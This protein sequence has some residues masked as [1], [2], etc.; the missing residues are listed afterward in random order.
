MAW[1]CWLSLPSIN[2]F[3][4]YSRSV[5]IYPNPTNDVLNITNSQIN[6]PIMATITN[7]LGQVVYASILT[8]NQMQ[9]NISH[10]PTSVYS[11]AISNKA[12]T[13]YKK[14]IKE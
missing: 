12:S 9:I 3:N 6:E 4:E 5:N 1:Y 11:I 14:L 10:L 7:E 2:Q 8:T 13:V